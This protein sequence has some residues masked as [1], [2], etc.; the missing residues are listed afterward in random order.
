M[1][2]P[3]VLATAAVLLSTSPAFAY[4]AL[5]IGGS[6]AEAASKGIADGISSNQDT[7]E[8]AQA[9]AEK[10]CLAYT[11]APAVA[12][13]CKVIETFSHK[14]VVVAM[15]PAAGTPGFGWSI[16]ADKATA[17][18]NAVD[19]C[20]ATSPDNRKP[21]CKVDIERGDKTP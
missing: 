12:A 18:Q 14:W 10:F 4:G 5:A 9:A 2:K 1:L 3:S 11:G 21:F 19:Q 13:Q 15:D 16:D 6:P 20:K 7:A 8:E 17:E